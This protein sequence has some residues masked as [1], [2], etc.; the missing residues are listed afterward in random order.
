MSRFYIDGD[1]GKLSIIYE[2]GA[3]YR[4]LASTEDEAMRAFPRW[5]NRASR[6]A[7]GGR[8]PRR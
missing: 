8:F 1:D 5:P 6:H 2:D 3:E 7:T 4:D